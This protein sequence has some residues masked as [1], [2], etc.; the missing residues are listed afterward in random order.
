[1][2]KKKYLAIIMALCVLLCGCEMTWLDGEYHSVT[3]HLQRDEQQEDTQTVCRNYDEIRDS[4]LEMVENG[5][6]KG[7]IYTEGFSE[8]EMEAHILKAITFATKSNAIGAYAVDGITFDVGTNAATPAIA[9]EISYIHDR[10]EIVRIKRTQTMQGAVNLITAAL[11]NCNEGITLLVERYTTIDLTQLVEDYVDDNPHICMETPQVNIVTYPE[12][13]IRRVL[14]LTFTY[15]TSRDTLR[16]MQDNVAPVFSS[17]ELYVRGD[18][19]DAEKYSQLYSFLMERYEYTVETSITPSYS[20]LRH[21]VGDSKAFARVYAQMCKQAGLKCQVISGT[22]AGEAW[23]WNEV[24][25]EDT[26]YYIDLLE[27]KLTGVFQPKLQ[28]EMTG[29]VWDY[30]QISDGNG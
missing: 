24:I 1:M 18:A 5:T 22:K 7:M 16:M 3:P 25:I 30:S 9:V 4:L 10:S 29:Y 8:D 21:G 19:L 13:G 11:D 23:Y 12:R 28:E 17:A 20:L 2:Y 27:C 6:T 26:V 15:Q 14:Q